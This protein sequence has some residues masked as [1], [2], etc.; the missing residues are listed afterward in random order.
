MFW[1][2]VYVCHVGPLPAM[3]VVMESAFDD[4]TAENVCQ[5][6]FGLN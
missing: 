3:M 1:M 2:I 6:E 4:C 5:C